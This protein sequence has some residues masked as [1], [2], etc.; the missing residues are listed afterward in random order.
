MTGNVKNIF[1]LPISDIDDRR[2]EIGGNLKME[3]G[4]IAQT[5]WLRI[6]LI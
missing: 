1:K 6:R 3:E 2:K 4:V 5:G